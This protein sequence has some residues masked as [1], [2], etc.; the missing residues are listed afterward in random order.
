[1]RSVIL[2]SGRLR[3][4][5][6]DCVPLLLDVLLLEPVEPSAAVSVLAQA[7]RPG[8]AGVSVPSLM[9]SLTNV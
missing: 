6:V 2:L 4:F 3:Y 1:M 7:V 9:P 8:A 5:V